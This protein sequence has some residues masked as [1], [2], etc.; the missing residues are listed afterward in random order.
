MTVK[1]FIKELE[2]VKKLA[3]N[4]NKSYVLLDLNLPVL[5]QLQESEYNKWIE[6]FDGAFHDKELTQA[7]KQEG[8]ALYSFDLETKQTITQLFLLYKNNRR[9]LEGQNKKWDDTCDFN[10]WLKL[11]KRA[12]LILNNWKK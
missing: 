6:K 8:K 11:I 4:I 1:E 2:E 5:K 3:G 7:F 9:W 12:L 10:E